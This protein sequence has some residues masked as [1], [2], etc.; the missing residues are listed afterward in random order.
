MEN[1]QERF[2]SRLSQ[3]CRAFYGNLLEKYEGN[4]EVIK[5]FDLAFKALQTAALVDGEFLAV[6]GGISPHMT[7]VADINKIDRFTE[8][9]FNENDFLS[10][11]LW[12][13]PASLKKELKMGFQE[14]T[15]RGTG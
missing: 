2:D 10:D 3:N 4:M 12:S 13:D 5:C 8:S 11:L 6:H 15:H 1:S 9:S 14:N 7:K